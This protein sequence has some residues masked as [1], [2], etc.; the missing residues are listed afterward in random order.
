MT[1]RSAYNAYRERRTLD[2]IQSVAD[3]RDLARRRVP[4]SVFQM[5]EAGSGSDITARRNEEVFSEVLFR[6]RNAVSLPEHDISTT[7]LGHRISMP[8]IV[9]SVGFLGVAHSDGEAGV[10]VPPARPARS[11]SSPG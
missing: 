5:F 7:V 11:S 3:A 6:P 4:A 10:G 8:L 1:G 9:S 2:R